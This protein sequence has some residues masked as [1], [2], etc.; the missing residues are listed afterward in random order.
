MTN[1]RIGHENGMS[2][3]QVRN[4][5]NTQLLRCSN[6]DTNDYVE[7]VQIMVGRTILKIETSTLQQGCYLFNTA[8]L[9]IFS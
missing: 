1:V 8:L 9:L 3:C 4:D 7:W 2:R 6:V 5:D